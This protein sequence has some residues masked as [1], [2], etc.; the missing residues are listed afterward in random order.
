MMMVIG[1]MNIGKMSIGV[2]ATGCIIHMDTTVFV[3]SGG[4]HGGGIGIGGSAIGA[5][6]SVGISFTMDSMLYGM[7]MVAGGLDHDMVAGYDIGCPMRIM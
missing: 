3:L 6:I 4:I 2:T 5:I 1:M 7:M